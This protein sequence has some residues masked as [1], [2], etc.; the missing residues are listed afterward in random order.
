MKIKSFLKFYNV[1]YEK[2]D[3]EINEFIKDRKV[4]DIK[5]QQTDNNAYVLVLYE[6]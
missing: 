2:F 4:I 1:S 6:D 3:D 5:I